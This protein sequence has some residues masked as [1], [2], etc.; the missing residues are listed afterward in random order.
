M[1][2]SMRQENDKLLREYRTTQ[3]ER[4]KR[5]LES[6]IVAFNLP[7]VKKK[8]R[9][10]QSKSH[11]HLEM[12]DLIQAG[13]IGLLTAIR[14]DQGKS[15]FTTYAN[16]WIFH[17][18][19][20]LA[21]KT[22]PVHRP[23]GAGLPYKHFRLMEA[24]RAITGEDATDADLG[25]PDGFIDQ[26]RQSPVFFPLD[27]AEDDSRSNQD[28]RASDT[29]SAEDLLMTAEGELMLTEALEGLPEN[30]QKNLDLIFV[31]GKKGDEP[32]ATKS[33]QYLRRYFV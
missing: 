5:A 18:M 29:E 30:E 3:S 25:L 21:A 16:W 17:E 33:I 2:S 14:K 27:D 32:L 9:T 26:W 6:Q 24:I 31:K 22:Q 7:F 8:V 15:A 23:K 12:E 4:R 11:V 1:S 10:F 28:K 20:S 19:G 13:M